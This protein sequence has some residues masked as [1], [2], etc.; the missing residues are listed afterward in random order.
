MPGQ[1]KKTAA[2]PSTSGRLGTML[3]EESRTQSDSFRNFHLEL[4]KAVDVYL[5]GLMEDPASDWRQSI[6]RSS[7][8]GRTNAYVELNFS[9]QTVARDAGLLNRESQPYSLGYMY[10]QWSR[11][12]DGFTYMR[13]FCEHYGIRMFH[14][15][16]RRDDTAEGADDANRI[17]RFSVDWS[18]ADE[19]PEEREQRLQRHREHRESMRST[20]RSE[21][22]ERGERGH[23]GGRGRSQQPPQFQE[24]ET[25]EPSVE[26]AGDVG[27]EAT[28]EDFTE[29]KRKPTKGGKKGRPGRPARNYDE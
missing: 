4:A 24:E 27:E 20:E 15:G 26:V 17:H 21:R 1:R 18:Y 3:L 13:D 25:Q 9:D 16:T 2:T 14:K 7:E 11:S 23:T 29:V 8:R 6:T 22:G 28:D 12:D 5:R 19:T 10:R